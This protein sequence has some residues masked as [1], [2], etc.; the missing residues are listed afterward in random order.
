[1]LETKT[2]REIAETRRDLEIYRAIGWQGRVVLLEGY[3]AVQIEGQ[4]IAEEQKKREALT[5]SC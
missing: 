1:M 4:R 3:L 2:D 5:Y